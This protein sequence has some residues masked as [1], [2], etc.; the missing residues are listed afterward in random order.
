MLKAAKFASYVVASCVLAGFSGVTHADEFQYGGISLGQAESKD[1]CDDIS[2]PGMSCD[3]NA[4]TGR[5]YGGAVFD[6]YMAF[7]GGY[8]Y[9]DDM[10]I[11][12]AD[13][14][15]HMFDGSLLL[16]VPDLGPVRF[17][18]KVGAQFW[19]Q[20]FGGT[21][22]SIDSER[23]VSLRTGLGA[24]IDITDNVGLRAE[25][26]YLKSVGEGHSNLKSD[27]HIFSVG[28]ELRF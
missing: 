1:F 25:W 23:G 15:Y 5:I 22:S 18:G 16:F 9:I 8:R 28:P 7:E 2:G 19:Q 26:D 12:A 21:A 4:L 13:V 27:M 6:K 11:G 3:D 14:S 17:F 24:V 10:S 20:D